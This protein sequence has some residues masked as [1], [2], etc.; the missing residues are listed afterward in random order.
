MTS[1]SANIVL[2]L[3]RATHRVLQ[4]LD[5]AAKEVGVSPVEMNML[6]NLQ[7]S[8]IW[9]VSQLARATGLRPSTATGVLDRLEERTLL[10]RRPNPT[11]RRSVTVAL[12]PHGQKVA[13]SVLAA[14]RSVDDQICGSTPDASLIGYHEVIGAIGALSPAAQSS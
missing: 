5:P 9:T 2:S 3:Q 10:E 14:M 1:G 13:G 11:D 4:L 7:T 8:E 6:A 12:T